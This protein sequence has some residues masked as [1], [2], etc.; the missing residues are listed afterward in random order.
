MYV[1]FIVIKDEI[2]IVSV[3]N[4]IENP[5]DNEQLNLFN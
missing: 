3:I 1:Y 5:D 2:N 4:D